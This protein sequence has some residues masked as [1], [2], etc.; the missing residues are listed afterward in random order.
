MP[1]P[2]SAL[3]SAVA[4]DDVSVADEVDVC[5]PRAVLVA[6]LKLVDEEVDAPV[7]DSQGDQNPGQ[8]ELDDAGERQISSSSM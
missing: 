8:L 7:P 5:V 4:V 2:V 1:L 6:E 3:V